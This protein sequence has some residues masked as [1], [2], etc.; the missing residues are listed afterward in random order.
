[1]DSDIK[2]ALSTGTTLPKAASQNRI[3][4][5]SSLLDKGGKARKKNW[6]KEFF[7]ED[8]KLCSASRIPIPTESRSIGILLDSVQGI[9]HRRL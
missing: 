5:V 3:D 6:R 8:S 7:A 9:P 1:M 4:I 2:G